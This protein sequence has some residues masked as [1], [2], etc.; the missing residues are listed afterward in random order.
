[1][2]DVQWFLNSGKTLEI[3]TKRKISKCVAVFLNGL[4]RGFSGAQGAGIK[5]DSF[6]VMFNAK[7]KDVRFKLPPEQYGKEWIKILDTC[8]ENFDEGETY[9]NASKIHV[10]ALSIVIIKQ[11]Q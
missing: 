6:F 11:M 3:S 5:D 4:D 2:P 8:N 7:D 10:A 9:K 1:M